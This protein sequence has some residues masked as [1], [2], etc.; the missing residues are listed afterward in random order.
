MDSFLGP[1]LNIF[2]TSTCVVLRPLQNVHFSGHNGINFAMMRFLKWVVPENIPSPPPPHHRKDFPCNIHTPKGRNLPCNIHTPLPH[3][4]HQRKDFPCNIHTPKGR[5]LPCN[6]HTPLP[7][8]HHQRKDFPCNIQTPKGR[9]LSCNIPT[10]KGRNLPCNI[11]TPFP[12]TT[13]KGRISPA[14]SKPPKEG[15]YPAI[16][17]PP[18]PTTTTKGR[19][20]HAISLPP[21]EG[22]YP[23]IFIPPFP[24]TTTKERISHAISKR[25]FSCKIHTPKKEGISPAISMAPTTKQKNFPWN[26]QALVYEV[27]P[28]SGTMLQVHIQPLCMV[29]CNSAQS[30]I[31]TLLWGLKMTIL[32]LIPCWTTVSPVVYSATTR[33]GPLG[34]KL[35]NHKVNWEQWKATFLVNGPMTFKNTNNSFTTKFE[36]STT[37]QK[38]ADLSGHLPLFWLV[39]FDPKFWRTSEEVSVFIKLSNHYM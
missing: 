20:S 8:H 17:I 10:P 13:T 39:S 32:L 12:T 15:I 34:T 29:H 33:T 16:F 30:W 28:F 14:I 7:H 18:F 38:G 4:H 26:F 25:G 31:T 5:N 19:I 22:I 3:H 36:N 35:T 9:N 24:T 6:I 21:K 37:L 27:W 2:R 23:A 1:Y 11:H